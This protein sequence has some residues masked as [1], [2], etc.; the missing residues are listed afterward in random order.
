[1]SWGSCYFYYRCP[2]CGKRYKYALDLIPALGDDF[3]RCPVCRGTS[4]PEKE[5]AITADDLLYEEIEE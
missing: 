5:G 3:G 4:A 2:D 1:M